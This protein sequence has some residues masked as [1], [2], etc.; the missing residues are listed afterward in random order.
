[1]NI[2]IEK[3]RGLTTQK[4]PQIYQI[5]HIIIFRES[6]QALNMNIDSKRMRELTCPYSWGIL[7][8]AH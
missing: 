1:M 6:I 4:M 5:I 2:Y 3:I 8:L 7:G